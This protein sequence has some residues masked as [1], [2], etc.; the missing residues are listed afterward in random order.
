MPESMDP[1]QLEA[2]LRQ[3]AGLPPQ[4]DGKPMTEVEKQAA[5]LVQAHVQVEELR[6]NP[7]QVLQALAGR[8]ARPA[9]PESEPEDEAGRQSARIQRF[10][11]QVVTGDWKAVKEYLTQ[12]PPDVGPKVYRHLL[13]LLA[14]RVHVVLLPDEIPLLADASP[15]KLDES[16]LASLGGLLSQSLKHVGW[17][18]AMLATIAAGT[19]KLGGDDPKGR[20]AA[21]R[22]LLAAGMLDEAGRYLPPLDAVLQAGDPVLI[23]LHASHQQAIGVQKSDAQATRRAWDL[24]QTVVDMPQVD[25]R[26]RSEALARTLTLMPSM[27]EDAAA[28]VVRKIFTDRPALGMQ[29]LAQ[30]AVG[31]ETAFADREVEPRLLALAAQR[32]LARLL[33]SITDEEADRWSAPITM[34]MLGWITEAQYAVAATGGGSESDGLP[35]DDPDSDVPEPSVPVRQGDAYSQSVAQTIVSYVR[36][37]IRPLPAEKLFPL[38][39]DEDW[40]RAVPEDMARHADRLNGKLAAMVGDRERTFA[41]ISRLGDSGLDFAKQLAE[42]YVGAWIRKRDGSDDYNE[43]EY[44]YRFGRGG[45]YS[46]SLG[47]HGYSP[48]SGY[49]RSEGIPLTRAKQVR[50]LAA[51]AGLLREIEAMGVPPL[52]PDLL[53]GGFDACH[54]PAEVY[55]Q[56]D[57]Q[58][59][60]GDPAD[61]TPKTSLWLVSAM[62]TRLAGQWRK[63]EM[64]EQM[65]TRRTDK[66]QVAE[67]MRGYELASDLAAAAVEKSPGHARPLVLLASVHFDQAEFL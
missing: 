34:M 7:G 26:P 14:N 24:T 5:Q 6:R 8:A 19:E 22:L 1:Q 4:A 18:S 31:V 49:S 29:L 15:S 53:V 16:Q 38:C 47:P 64:Q 62:R 39:P 56:E 30:A 35:Y 36:R 43:E 46:S 20:M 28:P 2:L 17:P 51:F 66:Q 59:V 48:Y 40:R 10:Y 27:P 44:G 58:R 67:V 54:S 21:A 25:D 65:N 13:T 52:E 63:L 60:F 32:Q 42:Q 61:L 57:V 55:R 37:K 11:Q 23:N 45:Y 3:Q 9:E 12:L 41:A 50:D 33:L